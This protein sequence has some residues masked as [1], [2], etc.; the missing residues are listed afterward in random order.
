V[1]DLVL[2][3]WQLLKELKS[4]MADNRGVASDEEDLDILHFSSEVEPNTEEDKRIPL[5]FIDDVPYTVPKAPRQ[6][7]GLK[8]LQIL[9]EEGEGEATFFL[10][11][12]MLG[13]EGYQAL[14]DYGESGKLADGQFEAVVAKALRIMTRADQ[15]PKGS[16]NGRRLRRR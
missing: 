4:V 9:H 2:A 15:S 3:V 12:E 13:E 16:L 7:I 5:F 11:T 1:L 10:M 6:T 8:Y 14:L